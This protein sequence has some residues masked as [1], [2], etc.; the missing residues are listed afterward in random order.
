MLQYAFRLDC[1]V[2]LQGVSC[3]KAFQ[4]TFTRLKLWGSV[5]GKI[6]QLSWTKRCF[7]I[8]YLA[9]L[10]ISRSDVCFLF[11]VLLLIQRFALE[12]GRGN[13]RKV[14]NFCKVFFFFCKHERTQS[15]AH[16]EPA[17]SLK[18]CK[19]KAERTLACP[20]SAC[21]WRQR[22]AIYIK[23]QFLVQNCID[24][25]CLGLSGSWELENGADVGT[26]GLWTICQESL[27]RGSACKVVTE[28]RLL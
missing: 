7:I 25:N 12:N 21:V 4:F 6:V 17:R 26:T 11:N 23:E 24:I 13:I 10:A 3:F 22:G 20:P 1:W 8:S 2:D 28:I 5:M 19:T 9:L 14:E 27:H 18:T 15:Q 16:K